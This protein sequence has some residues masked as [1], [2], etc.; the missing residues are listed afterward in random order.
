MGAASLSPPIVEIEIGRTQR[1]DSRGVPHLRRTNMRELVW[2]RDSEL[3][4][5]SEEH[6]EM[7]VGGGDDNVM[8][9]LENP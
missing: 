8:P 4:E 9:R 5:L 2:K 7:V 6:L 1:V 3:D